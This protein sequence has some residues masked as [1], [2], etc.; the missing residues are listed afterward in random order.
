MQNILFVCNTYYQL[1]MAINM[2]ITLF[3][4][5][6]VTLLLSNHSKN[7]DVITQN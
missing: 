3:K 1:I 7:A 6:K 2:R 5:D 4:N